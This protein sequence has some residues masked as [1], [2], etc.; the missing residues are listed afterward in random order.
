MICGRCN[1][2]IRI[3]NSHLVSA[4]KLL[5]LDFTEMRASLLRGELTYSDEA[6][7]WIREVRQGDSWLVKVGGL[8]GK[9]YRIVRISSVARNIT[10]K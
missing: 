10:S 2:S 6:K 4:T 9:G 1:V 8:V 3:E 7:G 5:R